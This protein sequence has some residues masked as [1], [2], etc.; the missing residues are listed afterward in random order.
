VNHAGPIDVAV[1]LGEADD[2]VNAFHKRDAYE[3]IDKLL[4]KISEA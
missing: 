1:F 4:E 3:Q 2:E